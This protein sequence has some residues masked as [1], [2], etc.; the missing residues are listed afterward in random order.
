MGVLKAGQHK[1]TLA[2]FICMFAAFHDYILCSVNNG[3]RGRERR[4]RNICSRFLQG[5][6]CSL[7]AET[8]TQA[9]EAR[10]W[11]RCTLKAHLISDSVYEPTHPSRLQT[12]LLKVRGT[13]LGR[14]QTEDS[15]ETLTLHYGISTSLLPPCGCFSVAFLGGWGRNYN[16]T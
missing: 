1:F 3:A 16:Q 2:G 15:A 5:D 12:R 9:H 7:F 14:Q 6:S 13:E 10:R 8:R 11:F 4:V